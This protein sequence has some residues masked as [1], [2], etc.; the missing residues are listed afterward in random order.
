MKARLARGYAV[1]ALMFLFSVAG[2]IAGY[3][4]GT[5]ESGDFEVCGS[6]AGS[7]AAAEACSRLI[8]Q[9]VRESSRRVAVLLTLRAR[10]WKSV[11][12]L[13]HALADLGA[14]TSLDGDFVLPFEL[15]ADIHRDA[16]RWDEA[17]ADY[18]EVIRLQPGRSGAYLNRGLCL[19]EKREYDR[20]LQD[21]EKSIELDGG[22]A[23]GQAALA[24]NLKARIHAIKGDALRAIADYDEAIKLEPKNAGFY[25]ERGAAHSILG[26]EDSALADFNQALSLNHDNAGT[27][28]RMIASVHLRSGKLDRS[29]EAYTEAIRLQPKQPRLLVERAAAL[30]ALGQFDRAL[31]DYRQAI[32]LQP[33]DAELYFVLGDAYKS[34][35]DYERAIG[36]YGRA[37]ERD[38][39]YANAY[40]HRGLVRFYTGDFAK[41]VDD[42][43][44]F[45]DAKPNAHSALLLYLAR[46]RIGK[47][48]EAKA[49]LARSAPKFKPDE[50]PQPIVDLYLGK[51]SVAATEGA[52]STP[53]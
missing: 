30:N 32:E 36:E 31:A 33:D 44:R 39:G 34:K 21:L 14:A 12:D 1:V 27:L 6:T 50:W 35:N 3:A 22:N 29:V 52:A 18:D 25:L 45:G 37:I 11:G 2:S 47:A 26:Q 5:P 28:W 38:A 23:F 40:G 7:A 19:I 15:R 46:A 43:K 49:E 41:S 8:D 20:A 53:I 48:N 51:K 24:W 42:L 10:V 17:I 16:A 4:Q 9:E 13:E